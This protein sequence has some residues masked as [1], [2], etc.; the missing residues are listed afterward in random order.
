PEPLDELQTVH[1]RHDQI[2]D[3][4]LGMEALG[5]LEALA[6]VVGDGHMQTLVLEGRLR[7]LGEVAVILDQ[8][9][10]EILTAVRIHPYAN[11]V[12]PPSTLRRSSGRK[13]ARTSA[14]NPGGSAPACKISAFRHPADPRF[15]A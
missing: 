2:S 15:T 13:G 12:S 8:E 5:H 6:S 7:H 10:E 14:R 1:H 4:H 11:D 9:N 3:D